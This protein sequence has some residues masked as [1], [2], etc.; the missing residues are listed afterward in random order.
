MQRMQMEMTAAPV[1]L[2][3]REQTPTGTNITKSV[4]GS[5]VRTNSRPVT[6]G[7]C[8]VILV[9][10]VKAKIV[11]LR[12]QKEAVMYM[13]SVQD[14]DDEMPYHALLFTRAMKK[15]ILQ[16]CETEEEK[17]EARQTWLAAKHESIK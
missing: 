1:R 12:K 6:G 3:K 8:A 5:G 14:D 10:T 16:Q 11:H 15:N 2:M 9:K 13:S 4:S 7:G 17:A